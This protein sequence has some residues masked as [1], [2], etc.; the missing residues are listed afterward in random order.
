MN[1]YILTRQ[2]QDD[3][4][5]RI[6]SA[7]N[8]G[9]FTPP[10]L[11]E[12]LSIPGAQGGAN[13]G[14]TA[15]NPTDGTV[16][17]LSINVPSFYKLDLEPPVPTAAAGRGNAPAAL[18][19]RGQG[20][21]VQRCQSCHMPALE[22]N[23][24]NVKSLVGIT[25]RMGPNVIREVVTGGRPGMPAFNDIPE[26]DMSSLVAFLGSANPAGRGGPPARTPVGGTVVASG[27]APGNKPPAAGGRVGGMAGPP[28]PAGIAVPS[29][30]YYTGYGMVNNVVKP[31]VLDADRL[32]LEQGRHQ[33]AGARRR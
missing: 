19:Q 13:W 33:V 12:T 3:W 31:P 9:L 14:T 27:G 28:Y 8:T 21:Y 17:V 7:R 10:G 22:G 24:V 29:V 20:I 23:G 32:R 15:S 26:A 30:R 5:K 25:S 18:I 11:V 1:P 2:E 6:D 16:Y 4:K